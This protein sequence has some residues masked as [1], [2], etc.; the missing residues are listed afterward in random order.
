MSKHNQGSVFHSPCGFQK[1]NG[2]WANVKQCDLM[3]LRQIQLVYSHIRLNKTKKMKR[4]F[5]R[6]KVN[7]S[8]FLT[9][10]FDWVRCNVDGDFNAIVPRKFFAHLYGAWN[11]WMCVWV[12]VCAFWLVLR[13]FVYVLFSMLTMRWSWRQFSILFPNET[14]PT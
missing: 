6:V 7:F 14:K 9:F 1:F 2:F 11:S 4:N 13:H 3:A 10:L 12:C 8:W 5:S